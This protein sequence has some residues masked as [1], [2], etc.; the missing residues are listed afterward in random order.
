MME[1]HFQLIN[2]LRESIGFCASLQYS[3]L[4]SQAD[5]SKS[6]SPPS[7]FHRYFVVP[8]LALERRIFLRMQIF[9]YADIGARSAIPIAKP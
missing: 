1:K 8:G 3:L 5:S 6:N 9:R 2:N 7:D 4:N